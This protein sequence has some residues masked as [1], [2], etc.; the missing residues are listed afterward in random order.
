LLEA[1]VSPTLE[2]MM[3]VEPEPLY[4]K[5]A[6]EFGISIIDPKLLN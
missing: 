4:K 5:L 1:F 3:T 2:V 6:P